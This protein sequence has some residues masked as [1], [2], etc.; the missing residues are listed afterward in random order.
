MSRC[1]SDFVPG[2]ILGVDRVVIGAVNFPGVLVRLLCLNRLVAKGLQFTNWL[3]QYPC[4]L[5]GKTPTSHI[6]V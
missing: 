6:T 3:N 4:P 2:S 1:S 5:L